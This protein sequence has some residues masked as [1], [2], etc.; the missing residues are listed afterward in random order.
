MKY[1]QIGIMFWGLA[2]SALAHAAPCLPEQ[3]PV[4]IFPG[5]AAVQQDKVAFTGAVQDAVMDLTK[6]TKRPATAINMAVKTMKDAVDNARTCTPF[7]YSGNL[8]HALALFGND[9]IVLAQSKVDNEGVIVLPPSSKIETIDQISLGNH[10]FVVPDSITGAM[11]SGYLAQNGKIGSKAATLRTMVD[12]SRGF[13]ALTPTGKDEKG[14]LQYRNFMFLSVLEG[15]DPTKVVIAARK[16]AVE[17]YNADMRSKNPL[18]PQL[19]IL[20]N[21]A[22]F[23]GPGP[24]IYAS[25][26]LPKSTIDVLTKNA[27][28]LGPNHAHKVLDSPSGYVSQKE[29]FNGMV[30]LYRRYQ[31]TLLEVSKNK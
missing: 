1:K 28:A 15:I 2:L 8:P 19:R 26:N 27:L 6:G 20:A 23:T 13:Q 10:V 16:G 14:S 31:S 25:K 11:V 22:A 21:A 18:A 4:L 7:F 12:Q 3:G 24:A 5:A 29:S 30:E 17:A 9:L